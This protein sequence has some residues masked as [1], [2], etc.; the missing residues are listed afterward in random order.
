MRIKTILI[1]LMIFIFRI[2][3]LYTTQLGIKNFEKEEQNLIVKVIGMNMK[4][5]FI[6]EVILALLL[7]ACYLLYLKNKSLFV[8][9][10]NNLNQYINLFF[11]NKSTVNIKDWLTYFNFKKVLVLFGSCI[12]LYIIT[13]SILFC[14]NNYWAG[15]YNE[16]N[17]TA[18]KYYL[19]FNDYYFFDFVIFIF[20]VLFLLFLLVRKL[21]K[22]YNLN[23]ESNK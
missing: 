1:C 21:Y 14:L 12:P 4:T 13:T 16:N 8:I 18:I 22:E 2:I 11:L 17:Q 10:A 19:I 5:F 20:P 15:L 23:I 7:V 3:D 9:K 6:T